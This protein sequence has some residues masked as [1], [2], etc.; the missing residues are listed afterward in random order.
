M[1]GAGLG[2]AAETSA[3]FHALHGVDSHHCAR[4]IGVE[5]A[6][7]GPAPTDR[8]AFRHHR[9]T[10]AAGIA[11]LPQRVHEFLQ[12]WLD[13]V[14]GGKEGIRVAVHP[15]LERDRL[16]TELRQMAADGLSAA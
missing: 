15:A 10:R 14:I 12:L 6:V 8:H 2:N 3:D 11:R 5:L 13:R 16:R 9:V 4:E 1:L 7:Y